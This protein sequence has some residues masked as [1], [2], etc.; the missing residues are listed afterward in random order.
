[1][2]ASLGRTSAEKI[3]EHLKRGQPHSTHLKN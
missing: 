2:I 3:L 1:M